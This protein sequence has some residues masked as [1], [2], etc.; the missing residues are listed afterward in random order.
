[1]FRASVAIL[2]VALG[3]GSTSPAHA[4]GKFNKKLKIGD[5]SPTYINLPGIDGK[6]HSFA[7]L[8]AKDVVVLAITTNHCAIAISYEKRIIDFVKKH[9]GPESKVGF[10][11]I[12]VNTQEIDRLPKMIERA[13]DKGFNFPYLF[14]E[15]QKIGVELGATVTPEFFVL[16]KERRIVYMGAM[17]DSNLEKAARTNYLEMAVEATLKGEMPAVTETMPRGCVVKYAK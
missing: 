7:D 14:D 10:V 8:K 17:D 11:A 3:L 16:N 9:A 15:S 4:Q 13:T 5:S 6:T 2:L 1:M 12:N